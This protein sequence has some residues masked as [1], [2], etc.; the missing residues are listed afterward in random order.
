V[1][2]IYLFLATALFILTALG[3]DKTGLEWIPFA[4]LTMPWSRFNFALA[5][6]G[7]LLNAVILW[8]LATALQVLFRG[9]RGK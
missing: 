9:F 1:G 5:I 8:A 3:S 2:G 4:I 7:A 6:P